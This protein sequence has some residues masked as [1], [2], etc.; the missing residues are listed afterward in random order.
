MGAPRACACCRIGSSPCA[1]LSGFAAIGAAAAGAGGCCARAAS[2]DVV[3]AATPSSS[4]NRRRVAVS[5]NDI[6]RSPRPHAATVRESR[7]SPKENTLGLI[8]VSLNCAHKRLEFV[9]LA[10][11]FDRL[12]VSFE[13]GQIHHA[14]I[15]CGV[16]V[17]TH[18]RRQ[19]VLGVAVLAHI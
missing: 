9:L 11:G 13:P 6:L 8:G 19:H 2:D 12:P 3:A 4:M 15:F 1:G 7:P 17:A 18:P 5:A 16:E 10:I 14:L